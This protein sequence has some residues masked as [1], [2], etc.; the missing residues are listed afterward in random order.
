MVWTVVRVKGS[1]GNTILM[2]KVDEDRLD[3]R[4]GQQDSHA[5]TGIANMRVIY[6]A[7]K[8][9]TMQGAALLSGVILV[10]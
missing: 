6:Q 2:G 1:S 5:H 10:T 4:E 9:D 7:G 8:Y 3:G